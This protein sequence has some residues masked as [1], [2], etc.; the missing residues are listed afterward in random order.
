MM[1]TMFI[2]AIC[3]PLIADWKEDSSKIRKIFP[4]NGDETYHSTRS[5]SADV[6]SDCLDASLNGFLG[7]EI[8][9]ITL[10]VMDNCGVVAIYL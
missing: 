5:Q 3:N 6:H 2:P 10:M 4:K 8:E 9:V 1:E 7:N